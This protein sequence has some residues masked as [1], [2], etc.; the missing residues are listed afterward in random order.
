MYELRWILLAAGAVLVL[1]LWVWESRRSRAA[2]SSAEQVRIAERVEPTVSEG[3]VPGGGGKLE[4]PAIRPTSADRVAP[5]LNPPVVEIPAGVEPELRREPEFRPDDTFAGTFPK[6]DPAIVNA[7]QRLPWVRTQPLE[8]PKSAAKAAQA[9]ASVAGP[10]AGTRRRAELPPEP[11]PKPSARQRIIALRL[12]SAGERWTGRVLAEAFEAEGMRFGKYSIYHYQRDDG[13]TVFYAASLVE[14]GSF[15]GERLDESSYPG[16]SLFAVL[17]GPLDAPSAFD[18]LLST[19]RRLAD[20]LHG[21][22]QDEHGS[23]LTAQRVLNLREELVH[24]EH[25]ASRTRQR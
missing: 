9:A 21:Q 11:E 15:D 23:S 13:K 8:V 2:R 22:M 1:V 18:L 5:P 12:I 10:S 20:R 25:V 14:P 19:A 16:I 4:M 17:P 7:E 6:V 24:F 3:A